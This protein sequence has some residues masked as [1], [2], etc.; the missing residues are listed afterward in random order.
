MRGQLAAPKR[1][2]TEQE[3]LERPSKKTNADPQPQPT[4]S[5][6]VV[7]RDGDESWSTEGQPDGETGDNGDDE[8]VYLGEGQTTTKWPGRVHWPILRDRKEEEEYSIEQ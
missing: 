1:P 8:I 7:E 6:S 4:T 2:L 5:H 3:P